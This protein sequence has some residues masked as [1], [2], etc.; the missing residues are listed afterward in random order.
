MEK[1][2]NAVDAFDQTHYKFR[3]NGMVRPAFARSSRAFDSG[4]LRPIVA[5]AIGRPAWRRASLRHPD[6]T[7]HSGGT[8]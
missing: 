5:T 4:N 8:A 3:H 6:F 2:K 1:S 7:H